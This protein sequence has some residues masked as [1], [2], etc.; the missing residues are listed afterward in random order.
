VLVFEAIFAFLRRSLGSILRAMFGWATLALF[1]EVRE[2]E[3]TSL[4]IV[5]AAAAV[6]PLLL[7]GTIFPRQA[8]LLLAIMPVPEGAPEEIVRGLWIALTLL[9]PAGVGWALMRR[10]RAAD[11]RSRRDWWRSLLL[12]FPTTLG[13]G[14]GFLF[15]CLAVPWRKVRA[16]FSGL[17]EEH[18]ALAIEPEKYEETVEQLREAL[19]RGGIRVARAR[20]PWGTL[21]LGRLLHVFAG[22]VLRQYQPENLEFLTSP[23]VQLTFYP[24]GVRVFGRESVVP[25][26]QSLLAETATATPALLSMSLEAQEIEK[27]IKALWRRRRENRE[28]LDV[29]LEAVARNL[30]RAPVGFR[31]WEVL[32]REL[33]QVVIASRGASRLIQSALASEGGAGVATEGPGQ[34]S[35]RRAARRFRQAA[36]KA[37]AYGGDR[38]RKAAANSS[39]RV[40]E[41]VT[42]R[43]LRMLAR[44]RR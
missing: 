24:N 26:A 39:L 17:K 19:E 4:T 11:R 14:L 20:P 2:K 41:R 6:W 30:A 35:R 15:V 34:R 13:L 40:I 28:T 10:N 1:G 38:L 5:V 18:V 44:R 29:E 33:L 37:R 27:R 16:L 36:G 32:Y 22:A 25:R 3:R 21:V 9:I 23:D 31:D 42:D 8:A 7:V 12:G 43:V